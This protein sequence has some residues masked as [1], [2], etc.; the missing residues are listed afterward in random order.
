VQHECDVVVIGGGPAG[1][2]A[3]TL[4]AER[5]HKVVLLEKDSHPRFHIGESLLPANMPLFEKLGVA[6]EIHA[7]GMEKFGATFVS[8]WHD[9]TAGF[10]FAE[11]TDPT[12]PMAYQV[13]RSEFDEILFRR[14]SAAGAETHEN[15]R[16]REIDLGDA[17]R[18]PTSRARAPTA[19]RAN[20]ARGS[21]STPPAA[22]RSS[23]TRS[24][25]S[26]ATRRTTA[27]RSSAISA[28]RGAIAASS[29]ATSSSSGSTTAG[30]GSS[31]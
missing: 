5:G 19:R 24:R 28:T 3:A 14:A 7:I 27:P 1:S 22:T 6:D 18:P 11:A 10:K 13:R 4:L 29:R 30:S 12:M 25:S 31:R 2:S 21:S 20:G 17:K 15:T 16:V 23:P 8:P 26:G 9:S